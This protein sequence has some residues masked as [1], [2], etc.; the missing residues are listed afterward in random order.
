[1]VVLQCQM[2]VIEVITMTHKDSEVSV[3]RGHMRHSQI[4]SLTYRWNDFQFEVHQWLQL[5]YSQGR[6]F[7]YFWG[8]QIWWVLLQVA[9]HVFV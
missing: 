4:K 3:V 5:W 9:N 1:M 6:I 8:D 2:I 7:M